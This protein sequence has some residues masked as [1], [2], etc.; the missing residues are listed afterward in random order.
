MWGPVVIGGLFDAQDD[1]VSAPVGEGAGFRF[2]PRQAD[3]CGV[4]PSWYPFAINVCDWVCDAPDPLPFTA[5]HLTVPD[6]PA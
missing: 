3:C 1:R 2:P 4:R 5:R 6:A